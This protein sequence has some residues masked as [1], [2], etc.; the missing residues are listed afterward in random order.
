MLLP[1]LQTASLLLKASFPT[2]FCSLQVAAYAININHALFKSS[3]E[4]C[5]GKE[6]GSPA[7]PASRKAPTGSSERLQLTHRPPGASPAARE[8]EVAQGN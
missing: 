3:R 6:E 5:A 1:P 4:P 8:M 2:G 7:A